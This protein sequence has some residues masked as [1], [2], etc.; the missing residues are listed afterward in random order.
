MAG[1]V[2]LD[3]IDGS[4][5]VKMYG[6]DERLVDVYEVDHGKLTLT[7]DAALAISDEVTALLM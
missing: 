6:G 2:V 1:A 7:R 4:F 3:Y 5:L